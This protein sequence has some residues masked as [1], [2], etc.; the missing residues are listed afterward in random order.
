MFILYIIVNYIYQLG[1]NCKK[2]KKILIIGGTSGI[3]YD[4]SNKLDEKK[5]NIYVV[6]RKIRL[7]KSNKINYLLYDILKNTD[8]KKFYKRLIKIKKIHLV[9][10]CRWKLSVE[11][12]DYKNCLK[13]G[14]QI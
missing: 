5:Y 8:L 7:P 6:G 11:D 14:I 2:L 9:L 12:L 13:Y 10:Y 3:G 4:V 1:K